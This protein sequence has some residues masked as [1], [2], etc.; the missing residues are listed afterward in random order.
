MWLRTTNCFGTV[1]ATGFELH[2]VYIGVRITNHY[3]IGLHLQ[4]K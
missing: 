3:G 2:T 4:G 1:Y